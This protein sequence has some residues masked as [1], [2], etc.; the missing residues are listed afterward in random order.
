MET[1]G[2]GERCLL[3]F[4]SAGGPPMLPVLY[5]N[6][7]KIVQTPDYVMILVE[8]VHDA[9][10]V[11]MNQEHLPPHIRKWMGDSVGRWEGDTLV[12]DTTNF[13][14]QPGL[15]QADRNL[16]VVERFTR[17]DSGRL[18]YR[19]E[20]EDPTMWTSSWSGE[21]VWP[22]SPDRVFE[23]ACHEG[24]YALG[25]IM[26]GARLLEADALTKTSGNE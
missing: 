1:R 24:N 11:R 22:A 9:R 20:V 14:D 16:H 15:R 25:N 12:I 8:M 26:R 7:K 4:G 18:L 17:L 2:L 13:N 23:Y 10:I 21:Y 19:F 6:M 5:N 3:G